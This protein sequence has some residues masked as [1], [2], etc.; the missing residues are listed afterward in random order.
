[1]KLHKILKSILLASSTLLVAISVISASH[2]AHAQR[3]Y[4]P[5][6]V[7]NTIN[8]QVNHM[9]NRR[10][11]EQLFVVTSPS[12]HYIHSYHPGGVL[13]IGNDF[14]TRSAIRARINS[15][16]RASGHN[17][18]I[19]TDVEGGEVNRLRNIYPHPN[20]LS[21]SA[22]YSHAGMN[23]IKREYNAIGRNMR[24]LGLNWDYAPDTD[25]GSGYMRFREVKRRPW[26]TANYARNAVSS[27]QHHNIA[28]TAK[29]FPGY[30]GATDTDFQPTYS[31]I[32]KRTFRNDLIP[33]YHGAVKGHADSIMTNSVI[34]S[35][36]SNRPAMMSKSIIM[37]LRNHFGGVI[38][39]D[40]LGGGAVRHFVDTHS[41][42][43]DY[44]ALKAGNVMIVSDDLPSHIGSL[45]KDLNKGYLNKRLINNDA[46]RILELHYKLG[47]K[48]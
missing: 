19:G 20:Y 27:L 44:N 25:S 37:P 2:M 41:G 42:S 43:A 39:T 36:I 34:F 7:Q 29:H 33:F 24:N 15:M 4:V 5:S 17:L 48:Y 9:S 28:A 21:P 38:V 40:T 23:G 8:N 22:E 3:N 30:R 1:M 35:K 10:K 16:Q 45:T 32:N 46:K 47:L 14:T 6:Q 12:N 18:L 13:L 26:T 31:N 11:L